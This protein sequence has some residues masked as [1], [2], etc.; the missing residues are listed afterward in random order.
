MKRTHVLV[1]PVVLMVICVLCGSSGAQDA[2][3]RNRFL[4]NVDRPFAYIKFD[5]IGPS[6]CREESES[7][8]RIWLRLTN[9]CR[10][11]ITVDANGVCDGSPKDEV[12]VNYEVVRD[13]P[14]PGGFA[15][16]A[17]LHEIES[18]PKQDRR[19]ANLKAEQVPPGTMSDVCSLVTVDPEQGILFSVPANTLSRKWHIEIPFKFDL[20]RGKGPRDPKNGGEPQMFILYDLWDLPPIARQ[21]LGN[22]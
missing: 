11:P 17:P 9:N 19:E 21:Q 14:V 16:A 2:E 20:P 3:M 4:L 15:E 1:L 13:H 7:A 8:P 18:K 12:G 5:H 22:K 10:I 6:T